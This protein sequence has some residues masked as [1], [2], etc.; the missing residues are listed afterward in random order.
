M[1][2][3]RTHNGPA[4]DQL[5]TLKTYSNQSLSQLFNTGFAPDS[6]NPSALSAPRFSDHQAGDAEV[7]EVRIV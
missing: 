6:L 3:Q 1:F 2:L 5:A 4:F 7:D